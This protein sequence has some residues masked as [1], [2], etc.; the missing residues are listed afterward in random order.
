MRECDYCSA[1]FDDEDAYLRH[2]R[3]EH[4]EELG[5][6]D[7]RRLGLIA[8]D[9]DGIPMGLVALGIALAA[10]V[11]VGGYAVFIMGGNG[12]AGPTYDPSVHYHGTLTVTIDG[13]ELDLSGDPAFVDTDRIFHFHGNEHSRYAAHVWHVHGTGVTLQYALGTLGI[14]VNHEGTTV[15]FDGTTYDETQDG[16]TVEITVNNEPVTPGEYVLQGVEPLD[17]AAA[18]QGDD[19]RVTIAAA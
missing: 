18:G 15:T 8:D 5:P 16:T 4:Q 19:I 11:L 13:E 2:L 1:S 6:I 12:D 3:A 14:E 9:G 10:A 7:R 17:A